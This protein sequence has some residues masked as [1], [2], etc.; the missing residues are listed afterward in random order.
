MLLFSSTDIYNTASSKWN[1]TRR[2]QLEQQAL[3]HNWMEQ[4]MDGTEQAMDGMEWMNEGT[5]QE[6]D[7]MGQSDGFD[8]VKDGM[9]RGN[10][11][12]EQWIGWSDGW[13][14]D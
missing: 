5:E 1:K 8:G 2:K 12:K 4:A 14:M 7:A 13:A 10:N 9:E 11:A 6:T 3:A